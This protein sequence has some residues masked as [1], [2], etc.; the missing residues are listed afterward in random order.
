MNMQPR[1]TVVS[2]AYQDGNRN[3]MSETVKLL[4]EQGLLERLIS[5]TYEVFDG[6]LK[7]VKRNWYLPVRIIQVLLRWRYKLSGQKSSRLIREWL[8]DQYACRNLGNPDIVYLDSERYPKVGQVARN[9]N[10]VTVGYQRMANI[11]Y[12]SRILNEEKKKFGIDSKFLNKKLNKRRNQGLAAMDYVLAHSALVRD[13]DIGYG[14]DESRIQVVYGCVDSERYQPDP[15]IREDKAI[16]LFTGHDPLLKGLLYLLEAWKG[17]PFNQLNAELWV[18]GDCSEEIRNRYKDVS[19]VRYLGTRNDMIK[20]Y[21]QASIFVHPALIDAGPK[22]VTEAMSSG[23]PAIVTSGVG[24]SEIIRDGYNGYTVPPRNAEVL[25]NPIIKLLGEPD[26]LKEMSE[27]ARQ[28]AKQLSMQSHAKAV[29]KAICGIH[30]NK[31]T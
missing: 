31:S 14:I 8:F 27:N 13:T 6:Q 23:L 12:I 3:C 19:G 25:V 1:I 17:V 15:E 7:P 18:V 29:M 26:L 24:Y 22:V 4:S 20:I 11:A 30:N 10:Q 16:V 2:W 28:S 5:N 9:N 21:Q